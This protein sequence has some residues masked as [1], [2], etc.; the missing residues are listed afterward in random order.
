MLIWATF[1]DVA[2][3]ARPRESAINSSQIQGR[4]TWEN[5]QNAFE[6]VLKNLAEM[7]AHF[8]W[9]LAWPIT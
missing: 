6:H 2:K 1:S 9:I 5:D 4:S 7:C 8:G 3:K